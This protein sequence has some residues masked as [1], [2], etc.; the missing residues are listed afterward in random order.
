MRCWLSE[1]RAEESHRK[2]LIGSGNQTYDIDAVVALWADKF[3]ALGPARGKGPGK[4]A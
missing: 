2:R 1:S 4:K 3:S